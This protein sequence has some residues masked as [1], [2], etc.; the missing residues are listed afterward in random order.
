[1][2]LLLAARKTP[3]FFIDIGCYSIVQLQLTYNGKLKTEMH[4]LLS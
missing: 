2:F 3:F 1:M 4:L